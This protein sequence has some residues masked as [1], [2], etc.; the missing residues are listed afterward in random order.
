MR[1]EDDSG[2]AIKIAFIEEQH[3]RKELNT[4]KSHIIDWIYR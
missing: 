3:F 4:A 2:K 1:K